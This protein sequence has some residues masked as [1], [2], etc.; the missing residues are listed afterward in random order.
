MLSKAIAHNG[1]GKYP[2]LAVIFHYGGAA[3]VV[4]E[5]QPLV[6]MSLNES[7]SRV[8][9]REIIYPHNFFGYLK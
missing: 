1:T 7:T 4:A 9:T 3:G 5:M 2:K 8:M 6:S